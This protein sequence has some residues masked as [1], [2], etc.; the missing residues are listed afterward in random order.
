MVSAP[1]FSILLPTHSRIDVI[2]YAVQ[3]VLDQTVT[4]FELLVVGDGCAPET[5]ELL[6][7]FNDSRIRFYD[8][9]KSP[10]FGYANR[11]I[12]LRESR[13]K[14]IAFMADD[15]L[16]LPDHLEILE[17]A[18]A[19][20]SALAYTQAI[21]VSTDGIAAPFLTNL[22]FN[23]ELE[24]FML[25]QNSIPASC[26]AYR[27]DSLPRRDMWPEDV[28]S[29][30]D[31]RLWHKIIELNPDNPV[32]YCRTP[33]VLHFSATW[34]K[35]R[36]SGM[37]QLAN[38][39]EIADAEEWWP[40]GLKPSISPFVS[41][42]SVYASMLRG[43]PVAWPEKLRRDT[44]DVVN[45]IAWDRIRFSRNDLKKMDGLLG[46]IS[47]QL[48]IQKAQNIVHLD[49]I[50]RSNEEAMKYKNEV[51]ELRE[52]TCWKLTKPLRSFVDFF[53]K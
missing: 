35:S 8:L 4:D 15:D 51:D 25:H 40:N 19:G 45:R 2:G 46:A 31:W 39:L 23:D 43:D 32:T 26:F 53:R 1:L 13:G 29:A 50:A 16:I 22:E 14:F 48:D 27:A 42:Q 11:N 24:L 9:P 18:L 36:S 37:A 12:A 21:W 41:E 28:S 20:E 10:Y 44:A 34:K 47:E 3:S 30:A 33:T 7:G 17:T 5:R 49:A 38:F 6:Q 52:S